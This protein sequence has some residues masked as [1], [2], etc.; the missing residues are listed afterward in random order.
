M[1]NVFGDDDDNGDDDNVHL[2][3]VLFTNFT[4]P[5]SGA[6]RLLMTSLPST[7][8]AHITGPQQSATVKR[9]RGYGDKWR[10]TTCAA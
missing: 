7:I 9:A 3:A 4:L 5:P 6:D 2:S 10:K 8:A 1:N